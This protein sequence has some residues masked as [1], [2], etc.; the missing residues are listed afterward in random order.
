MLHSY[1][2]FKKKNPLSTKRKKNMG[3]LRMIS[4]F[5]RELLL[6]GDHKTAHLSTA[7]KSSNPKALCT[8]KNIA[9]LIKK[10]NYL[11]NEQYSIVTMS[12]PKVIFLKVNLHTKQITIHLSKASK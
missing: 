10:S 6:Q 4:S 11:N 2:Q 5:W 12:F 1:I 8:N 3:F 7:S 9:R